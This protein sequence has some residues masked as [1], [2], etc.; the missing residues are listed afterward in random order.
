[1]INGKIR[2]WSDFVWSFTYRELKARYRGTIF[3]F[4]W[5]FLNPLLQMALIGT[6]FQFF[7]PVRTENYFFFLFAGLLPWNFFSL[8][9]GKT[10][11]SFVFERGLIQKAAFPR[12]AIPLSIIFSNALHSLAALALFVAVLIASGFSSLH[13]LWVLPAMLWILILTVAFSLLFS[14][15]NVRYRDVSFFVQAAMPLW[16]YATPIIYSRDLL[17]QAL[18]V[19]F[20]LNPFYYPLVLFR[21]SLLG[22]LFEPVGVLM[23][24]GV[25]TLILLLFSIWFF[26]T[27]SPNFD[28]WM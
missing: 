12:E 9:V 5:M 3:G 17:P 28:D 20:Y 18:H 1:M 15:L 22:G 4:L 2:T 23:L 11:P 7:V 14:T 26:K 21:D 24:G 10:T 19:L 13:W 27:N 6:I 16:F 8:S 25:Y